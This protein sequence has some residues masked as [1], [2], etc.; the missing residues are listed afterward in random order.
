M[1]SVL[2]NHN[3]QNCA[4]STK[5]CAI[6]TTDEHVSAFGMKIYNLYLD[7]T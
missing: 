4:D 1:H 2:Q 6:T 7:S 5:F 3:V